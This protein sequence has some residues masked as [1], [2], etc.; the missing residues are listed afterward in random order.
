MLIALIGANAVCAEKLDVAFVLDGSD[1]ISDGPEGGT[2]W[3]S[4]LQFVDYVTDH[5]EIGPDDTQVALATFGDEAEVVWH[6]NTY[7]DEQDLDT[8]IDDVPYPSGELNKNGLVRVIVQDI[9]N[10]DNGDRSGA[11]NVAVMT[12][13]GAPF[14]NAANAS[15]ASRVLQSEGI[16]VFVVCIKPGCN[17]TFAEGLASPTSEEITQ[18]SFYVEGFDSFGDIEDELL[19]Q[20]SAITNDN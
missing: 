1:S 4:I 5:W 16:T 12:T 10:E 20:I 8:A 18:T 19:E 14:I 7:E 11:R 6:L 13:D 3:D 17:E 15:A 2:N 9:F